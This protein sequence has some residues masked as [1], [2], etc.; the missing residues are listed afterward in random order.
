MVRMVLGKTKVPTKTKIERARSYRVS[1]FREFVDPFPLGFGTL[2]EK[3]VYEALSRR[4]IEFYYLNDIRFIFPE[5]DFDKTYQADFVIPSLKIIIEVQGAHWH[6]MPATIAEDAFKFA[7]YQQAGYRPYAW[8]D[9]DIVDNINKLFLEI[10]D[11]NAVSQT[12]RQTASTELK[13]LAR[14]KT[15][16]SKGIRTIN[17]KR[18]QRMQYKKKAVSIKTRKVKLSGGFKVNG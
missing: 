6:S 11:L 4:G 3:I 18:G 15:D 2:P 16:T 14:T 1:G 8:W 13:P 9:F 7:V 17:Y 5:I 10:P 12:R